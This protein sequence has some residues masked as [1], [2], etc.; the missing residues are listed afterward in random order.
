MS[1]FPGPQES[2]FYLDPQKGLTDD[3]KWFDS[4]PFGLHVT[5]VGFSPPTWGISTGPS[6]AK[7]ITFNGTT[8]RGTIDTR[9]YSSLAA[10]TSTMTIAVVAKYTS[11]SG[12]DGAVFD[13]RPN[14]LN[15]GI[16]VY[17]PATQDLRLNG[18][19]SAGVTWE[20]ASLGNVFPRTRVDIFTSD[21][22]GWSYATYTDRSCITRAITTARNPV[23]Y[24]VTKVPEIGRFGNLNRFL[25]FDLYLLAIW[26]FAFTHAESTAFSDYWLDRL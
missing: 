25:G 21:L 9:I 24:D 11:Y 23:S 20:I 7:M 10:A 6:G 17:V 4:S 1:L 8:Q 22:S 13:T 3:D 15:R 5:P 26:P 18:G 2:C 14:T 19:D 12:P 16:V